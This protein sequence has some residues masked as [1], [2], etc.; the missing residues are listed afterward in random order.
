MR[1]HSF[2]GSR[3]GSE[4]KRKIPPLVRLIFSGTGGKLAINKS[5]KYVVSTNG[6]SCYEEKERDCNFKEYIETM[7]FM[8]LLPE[9]GRGGRWLGKLGGRGVAFG[10]GTNVKALR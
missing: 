1:G 9:R 3:N 7:A 8:S 5:V 10:R 2:R 6:D 4:C